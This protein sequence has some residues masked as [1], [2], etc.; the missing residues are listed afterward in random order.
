MCCALFV[1]TT[2][3]EIAMFP[4]RVV[5]EGREAASAQ[6]ARQ[7]K[8]NASSRKGAQHWEKCPPRIRARNKHAAFTYPHGEQSVAITSYIFALGLVFFALRI[9]ICHKNSIL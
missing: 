3:V 4:K 9:T 7:S 6:S 5:Y 8:P 1:G 2:S